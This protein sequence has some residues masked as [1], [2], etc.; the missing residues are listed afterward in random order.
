MIRGA[1]IGS[2]HHLL[3]AK[4]RL[5]LKKYK[6]STSKRQQKFNMNLSKSENTKKEFSMELRNRFEALTDMDSEDVESHWE[7]LKVG[8]IET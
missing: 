3:L 7:K 4:V 1:D 8:Y 2:D 5:R 6:A